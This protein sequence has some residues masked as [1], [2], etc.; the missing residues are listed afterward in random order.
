MNMNDKAAR[1]DK[2]VRERKDDEL[3]LFEKYDEILC[4]IRKRII[5]SKAKTV[6]DIGCGT[7]NLCG[8]LSKTI[9]VIGI[10]KSKEMLEGAKE[11]YKNMKFV[12]GSF[13]DK[14]FMQN[15]ADIVVTIFAFHALKEDQKKA[16]IKNMLGYLKRDGKII[17]ADYMFKNDLEK[18]KCKKNLLFLE[19]RELW[20]AVNCKYYSK[21]EVLENYVRQLGLEVNSEYIVNFTWIVEIVKKS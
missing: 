13:L 18:E 11:K 6:I 7:G 9:E 1:F 21:V 17:I 8:Q 20:E 3:G 2:M 4:K 10:D 19:R 16:A 14:A 12:Q 15:K 5:D